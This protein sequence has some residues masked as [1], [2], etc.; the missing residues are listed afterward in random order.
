MAYMSG[1][2]GFVCLCVHILSCCIAFSPTMWERWLLWFY[3]FAAIFIAFSFLA[4]GN[5]FACDENDCK[6]A[7]GGGWS[8]STFLFWLCCANTVKSMP[9]A[10]PH[11]DYYDSDDEDGDSQWYDDFDPGQVPSNQQY[12]EASP[13]AADGPAIME[14]AD[15]LEGEE[16]LLGMDD[17]DL[18][19]EP[20]SDDL[21]GIDTSDH[22]LT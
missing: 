17:P 5:E 4:F 12:R 21:L 14:P 10:T 6:V 2:L 18:E 13:S 3:L 1:I 11:E 8:I 22:M 7:Q 19:V 20:Q 15:E 9:H 16:D